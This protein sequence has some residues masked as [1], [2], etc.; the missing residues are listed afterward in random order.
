MRERL[1]KTGYLAIVCLAAAVAG[2]L[3]TILA[4]PGAGLAFLFAL[5]LVLPMTGRVILP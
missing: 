4:G 1:L 3:L 5:S 2:A